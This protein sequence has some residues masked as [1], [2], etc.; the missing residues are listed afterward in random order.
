MKRFFAFALVAVIACNNEKKTS[1]SMPGAY[2]ML[3]QSVKSAKR[4]T[5]YT[6]LRQLK[7]FT[8]DYMMYANVNPSDSASSF[9]IGTYSTDKDTV[10]ENVIFGASDSSKN[11]KLR[12]F[13][14][15]IEKTDT[16]YK[17]IIPE[18]ESRGQKFKL[19]EEYN[20]VG[21]TA[22]TPLDGAWK[23]VKYYII[24]GKDTTNMEMIQ[25]K[26]YYAGHFIFGHSYTDSAH[27]THTGI[28]FGTFEMNGSNKV[29]ESP[30]ASTYSAVSGQNFDIDIELNG[31]DGFKQTI[32]N[33]DGS[34]L[35]E[36]YE[37][38]KK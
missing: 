35:V 19:T 22:K 38:L 8:D 30:V 27:K 12:N 7:I 2:N 11:D 24:N 4:D 6:T 10:I 18:I 3:S 26:T 17:Q 34:K 33:K 23:L 36:V 9:G 21:A 25:F 31:N 28:G 37:R 32:I 15:V 13:K 14:L 5:T 20:S 1:I 16:G 29:K